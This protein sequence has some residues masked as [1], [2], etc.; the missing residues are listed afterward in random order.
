MNARDAQGNLVAQLCTQQTFTPQKKMTDASA[1]A[2]QF[3]CAGR[4]YK[5][6]ISLYRWDFCQTFVDLI[7][8]PIR[9]YRRFTSRVKT[10]PSIVP[11][12][13]YALNNL[14]HKT[15]YLN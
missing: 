12:F 10:P 13:E 2:K 1:Y 9:L 14:L 8:Y 4:R 11:P 7:S 5:F 15:T 3:A 6:Q